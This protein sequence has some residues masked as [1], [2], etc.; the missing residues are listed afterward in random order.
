MLGWAIQ[1]T[2]ISPVKIRLGLFFGQKVANNA[3]GSLFWGIM[4]FI[5]SIYITARGFIVVESFI[6]LRALPIG[7]FV[8][9]A[10]LQMI[11]QL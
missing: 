11:P 2:I 9:P 10:W 1:C 7:V 8:T 5:F 4:V 3:Q 6:S